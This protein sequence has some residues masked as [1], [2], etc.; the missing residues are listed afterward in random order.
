MTAWR[1]PGI[2]LMTAWR[3]SNDFSTIPW[4]LPEHWLTT[5]WQL[6]D[7]PNNLKTTYFKT[8]TRKFDFSKFQTKWQLQA[9]EFQVWQPLRAAPQNIVFFW[10]NE[11]VFSQGLVIIS[12]CFNEFDTFFL[13]KFVFSKKA[14]KI[15]EIFTVDL[16]LCSK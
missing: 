3:L 9:Y 15:D 4:R 8:A 11:R 14:T 5:V 10:L 12:K 7:L 1:L 6:S 16:T 13:I 2:Q